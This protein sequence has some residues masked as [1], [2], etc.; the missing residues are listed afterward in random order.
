VLAAVFAGVERTVAAPLVRL[1]MLTRRPVLAG[2]LVM[3]AAA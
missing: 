1:E 2:N 3:L